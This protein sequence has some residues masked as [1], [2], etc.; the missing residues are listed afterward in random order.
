MANTNALSDEPP[1]HAMSQAEVVR[2]LA[3]NLRRSQPIRGL[4]SAGFNPQYVVP[5]K[6]ERY[7]ALRPALSRRRSSSQATSC[8]SNRAA[9]FHQVSDSSMRT[10]CEPKRQPHR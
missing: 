3:I 6:P 4:G 2:R 7:V 10:T 1:W 8:S 5:P 9:E